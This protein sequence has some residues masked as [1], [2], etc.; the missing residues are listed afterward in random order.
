MACDNR[1]ARARPA[2][3]RPLTWPHDVKRGDLRVDTFRCAAA[4]GQHGNKTSSG[5][6]ITH[7][8]TGAVAES[9]V[10]RDQH[11]NK[12]E[13]FKKLAGK[14][15][16]LMRAAAREDVPPSTSD[17]RVRSIDLDS[18]RV[19]DHRLGKA[20]GPWQPEDVLDGDALL[21]IQTLVLLSKEES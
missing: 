15:V 20:A 3:A 4:G 2:K 13:A 10:H 1:C 6:R 18:H 9:R 7:L 16:P 19:I 5:V 11:A 21:E 14:L 8:P 17:E 12:R